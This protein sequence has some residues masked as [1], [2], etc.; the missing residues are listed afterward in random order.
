MVIVRSLVIILFSSF[1]FCSNAQTIERIE[2]TYQKGNEPHSKPGP[3]E[4]KVEFKRGHSDDFIATSFLENGNRKKFEDSIILKKERIDSV[5][6]WLKSNKRQ[7]TINDF[8]FNRASLQAEINTEPSRLDL[9]LGNTIKIDVDSFNVCKEFWR[10]RFVSTGGERLKVKLTFKSQH[11]EEF[12]FH[13]AQ[14]GNKEFPLW[15]FL[16]SYKILAG[17]VPNS[18]HGTQFFSAESFS[19]IVALTLKVNEC[20]E[21]Y[22]NEFVKS[23]PEMTPSERREK[24]GWN[25]A[26]YMRNRKQ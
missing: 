11:T 10:L 26:E 7:F 23:H 4:F 9:P 24:K 15:N 6:S 8:Q 20:E 21:Y 3:T 2:V 5:E 17:R 13:S 12:E 18:F 22:Y 25:F 19:K 16:I 1:A 14:V